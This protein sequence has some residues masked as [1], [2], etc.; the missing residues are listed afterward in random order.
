MLPATPAPVVPAGLTYAEFLA[1][2]DEDVHAEWVYGEIIVMSPASRPHQRLADF[3]TAILKLYIEPRGLGEVI[4]APF[5]MRTGKDLPGREPDLLF[6]AKERGQIVKNTFVDG[7]ADL[8]V[9]IISPESRTRD[10]VDKF[11]EYLHGGVREYWLLDPENREAS[12]FTWQSGEF[13]PLEVEDGTFHSRRIEGFWI[14]VPWLW[15]VPTPSI[16]DV[17]EAWQRTA[18]S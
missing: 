1:W 5:Q 15:A 17:Q 18:G 7:P 16:L 11:S 14:S 8:V 13:V 4:S 12:F 6:V 3:L 9:E 10:T 2:L